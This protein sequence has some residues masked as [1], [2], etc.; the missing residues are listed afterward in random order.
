MTM[1]RAMRAVSTREGPWSQQTGLKGRVNVRR[2]S[3]CIFVEMG[4][5]VLR[6][7]V[8][9]SSAARC[10]P[11]GQKACQS[12]GAPET[13]FPR[14]HLWADVHSS[15]QQGIPS[16][17]ALVPDLSRAQLL[18]WTVRLTTV[19]PQLLEAQGSIFISVIVTVIWFLFLVIAQGR[20][21]VCGPSLAGRL[22]PE[23]PSAQLART[24]LSVPTPGTTCLL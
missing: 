7:T 22:W 18:K 5:V 4:A 11:G 20:T 6:G 24:P 23:T 16:G 12:G 19:T 3:C 9:I 2:R 14:G 21:D 8:W 1:K 15:G 10:C 13:G 17:Y